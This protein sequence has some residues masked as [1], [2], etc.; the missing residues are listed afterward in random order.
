MIEEKQGRRLNPFVFPSETQQR[1]ILLIW[2]ILCLCWGIGFVYAKGLAE[3]LGW[4][5]I[6]K[7]PKLDRDILSVEE[8]RP[9]L[10]PSPEHLT[11]W[12]QGLGSAYQDF[13]EPGEVARIQTAFADLSEAARKRLVDMV[14]YV[15]IPFGF[16]GL[17]VLCI[18]VFSF[19]RTHRFWFSRFSDLDAGGK[20]DVQ[21]T[22]QA[23]VDEAQSL[24]RQQGERPFRRP[25]FLISRGAMGDGQAYGSARRPIVVLTRAMLSILRGDI[26]QHGRPYTFRAALLHE[27]A[28]L[29][30]RDVRRSYLAEASWIVLVP[31]LSLL[32]WIL[33]ISANPIW[34]KIVISLHVL[35]ILLII[36]LIR[37]SILRGREHD[38]DLRTALLWKTGEP[39]RALFV[40][41]ARTAPRPLLER[42]ARYWR[43]HPTAAERRDILD[44]PN[45]ALEISPDIPFLAGLL[46]GNLVGG[47][48]FVT[49]VIVLVMDALGILMTESILA[50]MARSRGL[51]YALSLYYPV[52][53]AV[54]NS[55]MFIAAFALLLLMSYLL[56]GTVGV[57]VQR[58]S[59]LQM[60]QGGRTHPYR[61]LLKPALWAAVGFQ[62]GLILLPMAPSMFGQL[63]VLIGL[64]LWIPF[65]ALPFWAWLSVIRLFA[66][67]LL[68]TCVAGRAPVREFRALTRAST[69]LLWPLILVLLAGQFW[70]WPFVQMV[71]GMGALAVGSV[72]LAGFLFL[73]ALMLFVLAIREVRRE[74]R[75]PTCPH[76]GEKIGSASVGACCMTCGGNLA[77]WLFVEEAPL[78]EVGAA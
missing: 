65:A 29:A 17:T 68:G 40:D 50:G 30:N 66:R 19:I 53:F 9:S 25:R 20:V 49:S 36:E 72:G 54:W 8:E 44:H 27:L 5:A 7:L 69:I 37:R 71:K 10:V 26:R 13:E 14:P 18:V 33:F 46:F 16:L 51:V 62:A 56:A 11:K 47:A 64:I 45:Q 6:D 42:L 41:E 24:Q 52:N 57:Q 39:L 75:P 23:L 67:R 43:K 60:I 73:L 32:L 4:L 48:L 1:S 59:V 58:E 12:L 35:A 22:L 55:L 3:N 21:G 77:P 61:T 70:I 28:H 63:R 78:G 31:V 15:I 34:I 74:D 2:A 38:A 76:C